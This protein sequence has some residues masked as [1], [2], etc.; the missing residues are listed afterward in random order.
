MARQY[1]PPQESELAKT[2][3]PQMGCICLLFY[4]L[5]RTE[6]FCFTPCLRDWAI[7]HLDVRCHGK[8]THKRL[9]LLFLNLLNSHFNRCG[10]KEF[11]FVMEMCL[12]LSTRTGNNKPGHSAP[13]APIRSMRPS[14]R[15]PKPSKHESSFHFL[16]CSPWW[17]W[18][19]SHPSAIKPSS[20]RA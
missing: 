17:W 3:F 11:Y 14:Q 19:H 8:Q 1:Q 15:Y 16:V 18:P 12:L 10:W 2:D 20:L 5:V 9:W 4:P 13:L 6:M 7:L